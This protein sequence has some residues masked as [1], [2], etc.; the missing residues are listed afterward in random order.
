MVGQAEFTW[1]G[2]GVTLC[3][4]DCSVLIVHV[5]GVKRE[6]YVFVWWLYKYTFYSSCEEFKPQAVFFPQCD[7]GEREMF[8]ECRAV[9]VS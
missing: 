5:A 1:A 8:S 7:K 4:R 2:P 6:L 9:E 3:V